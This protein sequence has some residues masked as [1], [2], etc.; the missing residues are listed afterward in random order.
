MVDLT[1]KQ[2][3]Q[4]EPLETSELL[5]H[6]TL[7]QS[8][9][10][11]KSNLPKSPELEKSPNLP[12][13]Q[14]LK[15]EGATITQND[16]LNLNEGVNVCSCAC[17]FVI[18]IGK[19]NG[20][21]LINPKTKEAITDWEG[22]KVGESGI[23]FFNATDSTY[24]AVPSDGKS[25]IILNEVTL[26]QAKQLNDYLKEHSI[27]PSRFPIKKIADKSSLSRVKEFLK[28]ANKLGIKDMY[29]SSTDFIESKMSPIGEETRDKNGNLCGYVKRDDRDLCQALFVEGEMTI[30]TGEGTTKREHYIKDGGIILRQ[31]DD[32]RVIQ[33]DVFLRTYMK[34]N[35]EKFTMDELRNALPKAKIR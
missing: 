35:G 3:Q 13:S 28:F 25:V 19:F 22:K 17:K 2:Q 31:G 9:V 15:R 20:E 4:A 14:G 16:I 5:E 29:N 10:L 27:N 12:E 26:E 7:P 6:K 32:V 34:P 18:T 1:S 11:L 33:S 8:S 23:V 21:P 24:Q 30:V